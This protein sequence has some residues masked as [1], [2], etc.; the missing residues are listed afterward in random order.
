MTRDQLIEQ[1]IRIAWNTASRF[2]HG[3]EFDD[4]VSEL[5]LEIVKRVEDY[6]PTRGAT[7]RTYLIYCC[8]NAAREWQRDTGALGRTGIERQ[9]AGLP[10]NEWDRARLALHYAAPLVWALLGDCPHYVERSFLRSVISEMPV[11]AL[12]LRTGSP[13]RQAS[14]AADRSASVQDP[15]LRV[16]HRNRFRADMSAEIDLSANSGR[17]RARCSD[18]VRSSRLSMASFSALPSRWWID[19]PHGISPLAFFQTWRARSSQVFGSAILIQALT[20]LPRLWRVRCR[21]VPTGR[22]FSGVA[23]MN[24]PR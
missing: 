7:L 22:T 12:T 19:T 21:M 2:A 20:T 15:F 14:R 3:D 10:L 8:R 5:M 1:H 4:L 9:K 11:R 16:D 17:C 13:R 18:F 23:L 24:W 6:D